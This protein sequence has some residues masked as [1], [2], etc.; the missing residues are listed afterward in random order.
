MG[1]LLVVVKGYTW[2]IAGTQNSKRLSKK[3]HVR[4]LEIR[5]NEET[6]RRLG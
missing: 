5:G 4:L 1:P 6:M 2:G 3:S